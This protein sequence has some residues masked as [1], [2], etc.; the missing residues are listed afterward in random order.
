MRLIDGLGRN[1]VVASR[2]C[3]IGS[4]SFFFC[5]FVFLVAD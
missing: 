2:E 4:D 1:R 3:V 5:F